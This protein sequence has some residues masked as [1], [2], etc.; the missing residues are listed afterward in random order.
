[1]SRDGRSF[2]GKVRSNAMGTCFTVYDN[3]ENPKKASNLTENLRQELAAV[4]YVNKIQM[5]DR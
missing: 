3:G 2:V 1:M 4:I 5:F